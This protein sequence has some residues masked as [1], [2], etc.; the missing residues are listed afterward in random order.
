MEAGGSGTVRRGEMVVAQIR[1]GGENG[2]IREYVLKVES[3]G[4][5]TGLDVG[6]RGREEPWKRSVC[7]ARVT[8]W[9]K[10]H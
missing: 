3:T 2:Q 10:C 1:G 9:V 6:V 5:A 4:F 8:E 7:L